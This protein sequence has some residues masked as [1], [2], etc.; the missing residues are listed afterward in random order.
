MPLANAWFRVRYLG[1]TSGS[2]GTIIGEY[3]T[4]SNGNI[5]ITGLDAGTYV[6][7][8]ISAPHGYVMDTAPQTAY[9]SGKEQDCITLTYTNSKYGS[10]LIKKV[11]SITG[12]PLSD[13]Q[14]YITTSDGAVVG[15][16]NGYFVTDRA[17]T[18]LIPD[19]MPGTTLVV[20]ETR[21]R[22]GYILDEVP[23]TVKITS[24][25][26]KTLEFRNQPVGALLIRKVCSVN[27]SVTLPNAEFKV[28]YSDGTL[29]GDSNGVYRSDEN[30][31]VRIEGLTPG[32]SVVITE[33]KAPAGFLIDT[34]SQTVVIQAGKTVSVTMKNQP[35]GA[36]VIQKRDSDTGQPLSGAEFRVTTA[37]GCE[38]GLDGVIG[39][40]TL[41][42]NG[43]FT[44][45]SNGEIRISNLAPGAYVLT[46]T[47]APAGYVMDAPSTNVVIGANGDTQ[48][49]VITNTRKGGLI[50]E[51]YDSVTRQ[52]L[53]GA[54][55]RVTTASGELVPDNEGMT[56]SNGLYTTNAEGQIVLSKL[57]PGTYIVTE[58][59]APDNY[60]QDPTPQTVVVRAGDT[61]TVRYYDDPLCT[62][63]ILKRDTVTKK[64]LKGAEFLVRYSSG[65]VVGPDSGLYTTG[66]DGTVTVSGL[67]PNA[68]VVV[69]E[70]KAPTGYIKNSTPKNIVVRTGTANSLIFENEPGTMLV[71]RKYIEGNGGCQSPGHADTSLLQ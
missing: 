5:V 2:G 46:E 4:S 56:S 67:E 30:G 42:Q 39:T 70:Y 57:L 63:T 25:E 44:T 28:A 29:I 10:V 59:K 36:I 37:A 15:S 51:K 21:T 43:L 50:I 53:A 3:Q 45:D 66:S 48:T 8:E 69:S 65:H 55:F 60:R 49:V 34:Q 40:S 41:T 54:Q 14:F 18:I 11:D 32:K 27:P 19:I 1:G 9:I 62:L 26:T 13:I 16:S 58:T 61:Q 20:K 33:T 71:I 52:P 68:T 22:A 31:E 23:Q 6:C 17:G 24:N 12:E 38:V 35:K 64:P 47:K 7:E